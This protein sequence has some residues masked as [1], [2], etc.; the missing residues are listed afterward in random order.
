MPSTPS[1]PSTLC[2]LTVVAAILAGIT[3]APPVVAKSKPS[4]QL[5]VTSDGWGNTDASDIEAVLNSVVSNEMR[6]VPVASPITVV[7]NHGAEPITDFERDSSGAF[8]VTLAV[9]GR[10][11]A[12]FAYQFSHELCHVVSLNERNIETST[13]WF[14]E[15]M[16]EAVSLET[17]RRMAVTWKTK[18]PFPNWKSYSVSLDEYWQT[19]A[20]RESRQLPPGETIANWY[21]CRAPEFARTATDRE[22]NGVVANSLLKMIRS[23]KRA[24][25]SIMWMNRIVPKANRSIET[26]VGEW[27]ESAKL[28][29]NNQQIDKSIRTMTSQFLVGINAKCQTKAG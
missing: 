27:R 28:S 19:V 6:D 13:D 17:V 4:V 23:D 9:S 10:Q 21:A 16:C 1:M 5:Q 15:S 29:A 2:C 7:V 8:V 22:R 3:W 26:F 20:N 14:E 18:P 12:Q 11:W 25:A 24:V